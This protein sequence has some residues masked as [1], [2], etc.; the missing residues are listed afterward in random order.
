M[1]KTQKEDIL[2][3]RQPNSE[4][5]EEFLIVLEYLLTEAY[6][7]KHATTQSKIIDFALNSYNVIIRRDRVNQILIHLYQLTQKYPDK[8]P[9]KL[10]VKKI[11][12]IYKFYVDE[13]MFTDKEI[14]EIASSIVNDDKKTGAKSKALVD[15]LLSI[16]ANEHK[17]AELSKNIN[18]VNRRRSK[19]ANSSISK[20][21]ILEDAM[22]N[23]K[24]I[25]V[26]FN[27]FYDVNFSSSKRNLRER[28]HNGEDLTCFVYH[29]MEIDKETLIVLYF[30][31]EQCAAIVKSDNLI[32]TR[33]PLDIGDWA[34]DI[35]FVLRDRKYT[36]IDS[37]IDDHYKG[38]DGL[39]YTFT[40]KTSILEDNS[41]NKFKKK[42][43][44]YWKIP[45]EYTI[46]QR[47]APQTRFDEEGKPYE[48]I[49][50]VDDAYITFESNLPSFRHWYM[51]Y[52]IFSKV[53]IIE[54]ARL[55]DRFMAVLAERLMRRITKYGGIYNYKFE[56]SIKPEYE[57][58]IKE[59]QEHIE[60]IRKTEGKE[61]NEGDD[62]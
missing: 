17:R 53:V 4:S 19:M 29:I 38:R 13:R 22:L 15:K 48:E 1:K 54:P 3:R 24:R 20:L 27:S 31:A 8:I 50:T 6:D 57:Q 11:N 51:N 33:E 12:K 46:K 39:T 41:F 59:R 5:R 21:E 47:E 45:M 40:I 37:W 35:D 23:K 18:R 56:R 49:I 43:E 32:L 58:K 7:E 34:N 25:W 62:K 44:A 10:R 36:N 28:H 60:H 42:F 61:S 16:A 26:R 52:E 30:D 14:L 2:S 55:N 9:F